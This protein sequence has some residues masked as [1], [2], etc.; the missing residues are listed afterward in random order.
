MNDTLEIASLFPTPLLRIDIPPE[1]STACNVFDNT[2]M[3]HEKDSRID[4][5]VH[6]ENTYIMD[7]PDCVDLKKFVLTNLLDKLNPQLYPNL[8]RFPHLV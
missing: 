7:E 4:Y 3:L 2:P 8:L 6:S 1:L 5:G